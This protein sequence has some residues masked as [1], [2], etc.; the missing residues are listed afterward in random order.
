MNQTGCGRLRSGGLI[1]SMALGVLILWTALGS[2]E[3]QTLGVLT[4]FPWVVAE[5]TGGLCTPF[6]FSLVFTNRRSP[7]RADFAFEPEADRAF[8]TAQ[9]APRR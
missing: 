4:L 7:P 5:G 8:V 6:L 9:G 3:A 1:A 2:M